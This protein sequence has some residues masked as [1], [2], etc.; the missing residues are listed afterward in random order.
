VTTPERRRAVIKGGPWAG[1]TLTLY[2]RP[3]LSL[4]LPVWPE[5]DPHGPPYDRAVYH[6]AVVDSKLF[7]HYSHTYPPETS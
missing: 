3:P 6:R 4:H 1:R 5:P 7:Y 2:G